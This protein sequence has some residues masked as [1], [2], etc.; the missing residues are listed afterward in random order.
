[1][2]FRLLR[3]FVNE[4]PRIVGVAWEKEMSNVPRTAQ[5]TVLDSILCSVL[6]SLHHA[7][8][9]CAPEVTPSDDEHE[10]S[11]LP[12]PQRDDT[13]H[14]SRVCDTLLLG[15]TLLVD[16]L[17]LVA[18]HTTTVR[19]SAHTLPPL[20][21]HL[22][23]AAHEE[24]ALR[25]A[26]T[27]RNGRILRELLQTIDQCSL[28]QSKGEWEEKVSSDEERGTVMRDVNTE[29]S[30]S[31]QKGVSRLFRV[32]RKDLRAAETQ[33]YCCLYRLVLPL[34]AESRWRR[35]ECEAHYVAALSP[36][37]DLTP[38]YA[39]STDVRSE[40][41][42]SASEEHVTEQISR[43]NEWLRLYSYLCPVATELVQQAQMD[44]R[45]PSP[46]VLTSL[47]TS[48]ERIAAVLTPPPRPRPEHYPEVHNILHIELDASN[49]ASDVVSSG[50]PAINSNSV[51]QE[52]MVRTPPE[53]EDTLSYLLAKLTLLRELRSTNKESQTPFCS[54]DT[55]HRLKNCLARQPLKEDVWSDLGDYYS[56]R[57]RHAEDSFDE[58]MPELAPDVAA[59]K[60]LR[61]LLRAVRCY[62]RAAE[63]TDGYR[64]L[65]Q[66]L[67]E[68]FGVGALSL[69]EVLSLAPELRNEVVETLDKAKGCRLE[70]LLWRWGMQ[71]YTLWRLFVSP[72]HYTT[73]ECL[74]PWASQ[75]Q[76]WSSLLRQEIERA[77]DD[78]QF[79]F[80][81]A[82]LGRSDYWPAPYMLAQT[83]RHRALL[84]PTSQLQWYAHVQDINERSCKKTKKPGL[85]ENK[86]F[87][88]PF[89]RLHRIRLAL[90]LQYQQ[91][92][93]EDLIEQYS[94]VSPPA[95]R[96]GAV[97]PV[98]S[99]R[100]SETDS[101]ALSSATAARSAVV[102]ASLDVVLPSVPQPMPTSSPPA[103]STAV[104]ELPRRMR[105]VHNILQALHYTRESFR[106]Y[107]KGVYRAAWIYYHHQGLCDTAQGAV[108]GPLSAN[109]RALAELNLLFSL[110]TSERSAERSPKLRPARGIWR[111]WLEDLDLLNRPGKWLYYQRKYTTLLLD[112]LHSKHDLK[113]YWRLIRSLHSA[114]EIQRR[115]LGTRLWP[116]AC[117]YLVELQR[118][119][120]D[121]LRLAFDS[122]N[123]NNNNKVVEKAL[124]RA[125]QTFLLLST[126]PL[127]HSVSSVLMRAYL[128]LNRST[129]SEQQFQTFWELS[130][131]VETNA[132][133][134][135]QTLLEHTVTFCRNRFPQISAESI[136]PG[137][138]HAT[139]NN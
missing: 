47:M 24:L 31:V 75:P 50:A 82:M 65:R 136:F 123:N 68:R 76:H 121:A 114:L 91:E 34:E 13:E 104:P 92:D 28:L 3:D 44:R 58:W 32:T 137:K 64:R 132:D 128:L 107:H 120:V 1:L 80:L 2:A 66:R 97:P 21:F 37:D 124:K 100:S 127:Q 70:R 60:A 118:D 52:P 113:A 19:L 87:V 8:V 14:L 89:F 85:G 69:S 130:E 42:A 46:A 96:R 45:L 35:G 9:L 117:Q 33:S 27:L 40:R 93:I 71:C 79:C 125:W 57:Y 61:H 56:D 5:Y 90:L 106:C 30:K 74:G 63:L 67:R 48:F 12:S 103:S 29:S 17:R 18:P 25:G 54:K 102:G 39:S 138:V 84:T 115:S 26:C 109:D 135:R 99:Q 111:I 98:E 23:C 116:L 122:S 43:D 20:L 94:F 77:P 95:R 134:Q 15:T 11:S 16:V 59:R 78:A 53:L 38:L 22:L 133:Q 72:A 139:T 110:A 73:T 119:H 88:E 62:R 6:K 112:I 7:A 51:E 36:C 108:S 55:V 4:F 131:Y 83:L 10:E 81:V 101:V 49:A 129:L 86:A 41:V 105:M 126:S